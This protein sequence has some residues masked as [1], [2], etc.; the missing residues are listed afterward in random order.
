MGA[1]LKLT[2]LGVLLGFLG[3]RT[4]HF[5]HRSGFYK[6]VE[7]AHLP[8]CQLIKGMEYGSEDIHLL[9][10]GLAFASTG[11]KMPPMKSF[12]P[13]RPAE[14]L[15]IDLNEET[16]NPISLPISG[17]FDVSSLNPHGLS[18]YTDEK[19]GTVYLFVVNHPPPLYK[20]DIE[21]FRFDAENKVLVHWK[22]ITHPSLQSVNDVVAVG[23]E[24]F[25]ATNDFYFEK[26]IM[27][28]LEMF[29][30][31]MWTNVVYYSPGD[32][33][34]VASGFHSANGIAMSH[35]RKFIYVAD[36]TAHTIN[37][38]QKHANWSLSYVKAVDL[39]TL[40]DNLFVDPETGD[41]WTGAHPNIY[42]VF[43]YK[44]EDPPGSEVI[45]V[46]NMHSERPIVTRVYVDDGSVI[47]GSSVAVLYRKKL[48][49]GT[50]FHH[51]LYCRLE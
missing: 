43:N 13:D 18:A 4:V 12:A 6:E 3:E 5:L 38:F 11:L 41:V 24:S 15:L 36:L 40:V 25:Y 26:I 1:L 46:Q 27:R 7:P 39:D 33:R 9:P 2:V 51:A 10:S 14:I 8:N 19:D 21:I 47:Q 22:T 20:T 30:G 32:V 31:F 37:V 29:F 50:V 42:K 45:R 16:I 48:L 34:E 49:I 23:P 44:E 35:D 28:F 17:G